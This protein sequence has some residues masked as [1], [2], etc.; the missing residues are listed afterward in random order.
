QGKTRV[1]LTLAAQASCLERKGYF[2]TLEYHAGDVVDLLTDVG[3]DP[4]SAKSAVVVD[5]S[6]DISADYIIRRL[7]AET[8]PALIVVD[9]L[10][11]LDQKRSHPSLDD[12]MRSLRHYVNETGAIC[13]LISQIDRAFDLGGK[14]MPGVSDI[15]LPNPLDLSVFNKFF[16]LHNGKIRLHKDA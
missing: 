7:S 14:P 10:Q 9:Y 16:F 11:L 3:V 8:A 2:F 6:D 15:R 5:T 4:R 1:G 13:A 12:Q